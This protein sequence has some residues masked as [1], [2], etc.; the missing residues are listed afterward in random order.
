MVATKRS[1]NRS[2]QGSDVSTVEPRPTAGTARIPVPLTNPPSAFA[3]QGKTF[4]RSQ[5]R[6]R[7]SRHQ[8]TFGGA[9]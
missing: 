2:R 5:P 6:A 9:R 3:H 4:Y 1:D 7:N 8:A